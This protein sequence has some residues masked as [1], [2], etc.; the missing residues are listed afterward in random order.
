MR[1]YDA[2]GLLKARRA[3]NGYRQYD[4]TDYR[5]VK[6]ILTLQAVGLS[7][8][9]SRPFVECLR[10][11]NETGDSGA[12]S[13]QYQ[14]KLAEVDACLD[15]LNSA[16]ATLQTKLTEALKATR[17]LFVINQTAVEATGTKEF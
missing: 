9:D 12:D 16:K 14:Y 17:A 7:L 1:F 10:T 4:T 2:Q 15:Q 8:D 6:E 13:I 3:P 5:L 11:G